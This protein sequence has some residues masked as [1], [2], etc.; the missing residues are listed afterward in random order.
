MQV[1]FFA[2]HFGNLAIGLSNADASLSIARRLFSEYRR[3]TVHDF[4][5][6]DSGG[7]N[8]P[9][10]RRHESGKDNFAVRIAICGENFIFDEDDFWGE[11]NPAQLFAK[12]EYN[13]DCEVYLAYCNPHSLIG[14]GLPDSSQMAAIIIQ[15]AVDHVNKKESHLNAWPKWIVVDKRQI[16]L[17]FRLLLGDVMNRVKNA[18]QQG[19]EFFRKNQPSLRDQLYDA[20]GKQ[21]RLSLCRGGEFVGVLGVKKDK[22]WYVEPNTDACE[23]IVRIESV[24]LL[25]E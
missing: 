19:P 4:F 5:S 11:R 12:V 22:G 16:P 1:M 8:H 6:I 25:S 14:Q 20:I 10:A 23:P 15:I 24:E 18:I 17:R 21:V 2:H 7:V 3:E 13:G 9:W